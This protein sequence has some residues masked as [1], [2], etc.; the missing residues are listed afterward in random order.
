MFDWLTEPLPAHYFADEP[1]PIFD[2][3]RADEGPATTVLRV[4]AA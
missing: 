4:V 2:A 3:V 1:A